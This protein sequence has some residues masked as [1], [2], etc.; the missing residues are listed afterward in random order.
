[1]QLFC[2]CN[3]N[4]RKILVKDLTLTNVGSLQPA[5]LLKIPPHEFFKDIDRSITTPC[6]K[7]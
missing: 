6:F 3:E 5:A 1:M 4:S 2:T 7:E